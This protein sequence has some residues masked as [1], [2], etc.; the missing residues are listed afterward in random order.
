MK[1]KQHIIFDIEI[2][3]KDKP[4]FLACTKVVETGETNAFWMHKRG[5]MKKFEALLRSP[6]YTWVG[7]NSVNF[8]APLICAAIQGADEGWLKEA[9]T[10][11]IEKG[12]RSWQTYRDFDIDFIDFDHIDLLETAPGVMISLKTYA[13]RMGYKTMVDMPVPHDVDL[14]PSQ[15]KEVENYCIND[16]DVTEE[17]FKQLKKEIELRI[18]LGAVHGIDLRSKSDA[19]AAEAIL[20]KELSITKIN[21]TVP[22]M[23]VYHTPNIIRTKSQVI[24]NL[25]EW[26]EETCF[27]INQKNGSPEPAEWMKD[28][29]AIGKGTYQVGIGGLHS[30]H[31]KQFHIEAT[32]DLLISDFDV[33]SYYPNIMMKC[34]LIPRL[35]GTLGVQFLE[36]YGEIYRQRVEAKRAGNKTVAD[37]LKITLNG[38]FGKLG[39]IYSSFYSPDV[40]LGV[41]ITGQLNLLCLIDKLERIRGVSV[42]SANTDGITV[43]YTPAA[44]DK[45]LKVFEA[46]VKYTGFEYEETPYSR[47]AMKDVNNYIAITTDGKAKRKGLY[48]VAGVQQQKN[49]TMEVCSNMAVDYLKTGS[50]DIKKYTDMKDFVAVRNVKGGGIQHTQVKMVNDWEEIEPGLWAYPGMVTK[51]VKRKSP[52]PAREVLEGGKPFGRVARWYMTTRNLL[53]ITYQGSGNQV[54]KTA[55]AHLCMT[56]PESLPEDLDL[57]WYIQETLSMLK[58]MGVD[59]GNYS[60]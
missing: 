14:K 7:F 13:G 60:K 2:I 32:D 19:Q 36:V 12:M 6:D 17:L 15:Y 26:F 8:D 39:S 37:S 50:F 4:I 31:D 25:I 47:I 42:Y 48:A 22:Q 21:K 27:V 54:P 52:P 16:L 34:D 20:K 30:T 51:P 29:I 56:L 9:A 24:S 28:E 3:G 46:N 59:T 58:D 35:P 45:V 33:A 49:P 18:E 40:M 57:D 55:G 11:I 5:H 44:R 1:T 41:T 43:G 23:V 53:P 10:Q 38:T